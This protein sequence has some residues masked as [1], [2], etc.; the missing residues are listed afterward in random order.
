MKLPSALVLAAV[1]SHGASAHYF[2]PQLIADGVTTEYFEYVRED[3]QGYMPYKN[4]YEGND[5]RCN[6]G[7][8][9]FALQTKTYTVSAGAT[10]GFATDFGAQIE[11][12]GPLQV[13]LS[14]APANVSYY[15]GSGE[16]FKIYE[17]GPAA[18][19]NNGIEWGATGKSQ[20]TFAIPP[21]TP[22]GQYLVRI[23]QIALHGALQ[24][25]EAEFYFNCAQIEVIS[26]STSTP[27]PTV[28]F[29]G[30]YTG[31]EPGI[32]FDMY[33]KLYVNYTMP[34]PL[35]WPAKSSS[36][37]TAEG[38]ANL[39]SDGTVWSYPAVTSTSKVGSLTSSSS[40]I[41]SAQTSSLPTPST[42]VLDSMAEPTGSSVPSATGLSKHQGPHREA[43]GHKSHCRA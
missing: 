12:P 11:H 26:E 35:V 9:E 38:V 25:G 10:I 13:Y 39:P 7:S 33:S 20:F 27:G 34:G 36:N 3:T 17:L 21:E 24:Y 15:D 2:F 40:L 29:P 18:F 43:H 41:P 14:R 5:L 42:S 30:A 22:A 32:L 23:E 19:T 1:A 8:D 37:I 31:Y 28:S 16:W 4:G 6:V